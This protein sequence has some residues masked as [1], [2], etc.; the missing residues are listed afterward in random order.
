MTK[1]EFA[2]GIEPHRHRN[3]DPAWAWCFQYR[4]AQPD[5]A[6]HAFFLKH[7]RH[8]QHKLVHTCG[9]SDCVKMSHLQEATDEVVIQM[10]LEHKLTY[11]QIAEKTG[12]SRSTVIRLAK[13]HLKDRKVKLHDVG[14][15]VL[16][17]AE[18]IASWYKLPIST[19]RG[20]IATGETGKR[21]TRGQYIR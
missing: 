20:R 11:E 6:E 14:G 15:D 3:Q 8:P 10:V 5:P 9:L 16:L 18:Q 19:V 13:P 1:E 2:A 4:G 7:G 17:S 12:R 21:L